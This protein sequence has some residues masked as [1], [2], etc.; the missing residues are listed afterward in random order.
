MSSAATDPLITAP[1][2]PAR[3]RVDQSLQTA[4]LNAHDLALLNALQE[5]IRVVPLL[6]TTSPLRD[7]TGQSLLG[8]EAVKLISALRDFVSNDVGTT[9]SETKPPTVEVELVDK[10][11]ADDRSDEA[12]YLKM[13]ENE[14]SPI[15]I[16]DSDDDDG[17]ENTSSASSII[18]AEEGGDSDI[19]SIE[20]QQ[21]GILTRVGMISQTFN[22]RKDQF[23]SERPSYTF[24]EKLLGALREHVFNKMPI[25]LLSFEKHGSSLQIMLLERG[26]VFGRLQTKMRAT[27]DKYFGHRDLSAVATKA[28]ESFITWLIDKD[29]TYAILSHTWLR[30]APGEVTYGDWFKGHFDDNDPGYQKLV[31]FCIIAWRD[32]KLTFGWMDTICINKESSSELD[33]SIR[34]MYNWYER[35]GVCIVYLADTEKLSDISI[36]R[37]FT[38]GWTLQEMLSPKLLKFYNS[39]WDQFMPDSNNDKWCADGSEIMEQIKRA[40]TISREELNDLDKLSLSRRMQLA[41]TREVTRE[42]D[43]AYSLMGIFSVSISTAYGEGGETAFLRL[44]REILGSHSDRIFDLFNWAGPDRA[45]SASTI[46]PTR[47]Q[48]YLHRSSTIMLQKYDMRPVEPLALTHMGVRIAVV[49]MPGLSIDDTISHFEPIG[50]YGAVVNISPTTRR[51]PSAYHLLDTSV[52]GHDSSDDEHPMRHQYTFAVF[53]VQHSTQGVFIP[54]TCIAILLRC[55]EDAGNVT[56]MGKFMRIDTHIPVVFEMLKRNSAQKDEITNGYMVPAEGGI[57]LSA[58]ELPRHGMQLISKYL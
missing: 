25:R 9:Q 50:D 37:W 43:T 16:A 17:E 10:H 14:R 47:P 3:D 53:N 6:R 41:A 23:P 28:D 58:D 35:A 57:Y 20:R 40:T 38:R 44:L 22:N 46:L 11:D 12:D 2:H 24:E 15:D 36:D 45:S 33:E 5:F 32:H 29:V 48:Q 55:D 31:N 8:S 56:S 1:N 26:A 13:A 34:S 49:L 21:E 27:L 39:N 7:D 30:S 19:E 18:L 4:S 51:I 52:S 42:E 54:Q